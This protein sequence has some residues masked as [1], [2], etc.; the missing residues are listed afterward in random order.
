MTE[1]SLS[2]TPT[3]HNADSASA[4]TP[5]LRVAAV[6]IGRNEGDRLKRCLTALTTE[7]GA[8]LAPV[9]FVDSGSTDGS[10]EFARSIGVE[11]VSLDMTQP[12][13]AA[14]ARNAGYAQILEQGPVD[15]VF[16]IDGD[17]EL[18]PN[19]LAQA[20]ALLATDPSVGAVG[21]C[22]Q[23]RH[24]DATRYNRMAAMEW[25]R[26]AGDADAFAG[27][28]LVRA[29]AFEAVGRFNP[30]LIAGEEP[31]LC[32]RL[33][34]AG[35][36]IVTLATPIA[37]HDA[38]MTRFGQWWKR[39]ERSGHA[40]AEGFA[41][42][43]N[44]PTQHSKRQVRSIVLYALVLPLLALALIITTAISGGWL[45]S[46]I[47]SLIALIYPVQAL[48]VARGRQRTGDTMGNAITYGVFTMLGKFAQAVGMGRYLRGRLGGKRQALMEYK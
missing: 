37:I 36:R 48:R 15:A 7:P 20:M 45:P 43:G 16:F 41:L 32:V 21:G 11:V 22:R 26:P 47:A 6:A 4:S 44:G 42:H 9:V 27:D 17:C 28:G 13:T 30:T 10:A 24:P 1:P 34:D 2:T 46:A 40:Y 39:A 31:E 3:P 33:R 18:L 14:R 19:W 38:A 12:F 25:D 29:A 35:H 23:E 8:G 5:P